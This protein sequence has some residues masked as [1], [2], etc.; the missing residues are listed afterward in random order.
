[1]DVQLDN[2][3]AAEEI[4]EIR[5][6]NEVSAKPKDKGQGKDVGRV[7]KKTAGK[8][9]ERK[10]R[11]NGDDGAKIYWGTCFVCG[12]QGHKMPDSQGEGQKGDC[13]ASEVKFGHR[14]FCWRFDWS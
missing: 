14:T 3:E 7:T 4:P 12:R 6:T 13:A 5:I 11:V 10:S 9:N 1:M 8:R 2:F